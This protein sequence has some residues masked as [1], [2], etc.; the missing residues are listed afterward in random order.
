MRVSIKIFACAKRS[1]FS[2]A[3]LNLRLTQHV[4]L[5]E[6]CL[7]KFTISLGVLLRAAPSMGTT[8]SKRRAL[9]GRH[10]GLCAYICSCRAWGFENLTP[11]ESVNSKAG[12]SNSRAG[13]SNFLLAQHVGPASQNLETFTSSLPL[14]FRYTTPPR[15]R[16]YARVSPKFEHSTFICHPVLRKCANV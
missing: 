16:A 5:V 11:I 3:I 2:A 10:W 14:I 1:A 8:F 12:I 9:H 7:Q 13:I 15:V 4:E 6:S